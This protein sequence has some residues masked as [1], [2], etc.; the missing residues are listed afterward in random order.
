MKRISVIIILTISLINIV[1]AD[2]ID[3]WHIYYNDVK[4]KEFNLNSSE[5]IKEITLK[6]DDIKPTDIL[7]IRYFRD[8]RYNKCETIVEFEDSSNFVVTKGVCMDTGEGEPIKISIVS[9]VITNKKSP[10]FAYHY[11]CG[12]RMGMNLHKNNKNKIL[13]FRLNFE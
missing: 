4:I 7:T 2:T 11:R 12:K 8:T 5:E 10:F 3:Y 6:I 9:L 13:L 1:K